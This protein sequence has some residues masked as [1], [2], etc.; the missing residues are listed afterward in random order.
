ME[1]V[2]FKVD[3]KHL[4]KIQLTAEKDKQEFENKFYDWVQKVQPNAKEFN[5][6]SV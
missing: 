2:G 3:V 5:P 4:R 6:S 1:R